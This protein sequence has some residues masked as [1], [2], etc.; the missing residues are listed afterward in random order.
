MNIFKIQN[1]DMKVY[2]WM[3]T[4]QKNSMLC[5]QGDNMFHQYIVCSASKVTTF[6]LVNQTC[7]VVL[8]SMLCQQGDNMLL[9]YQSC[10]AIAKQDDSHYM[11]NLALVLFENMTVTF[12]DIRP[13]AAIAFPQKNSHVKKD[14]MTVT[15][16]STIPVDTFFFVRP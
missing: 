16:S 6:S 11:I 12:M 15:F 13:S 4:R 1:K 9:I 8:N 7:Q 10:H 2:V 5:K 3:S 14:E